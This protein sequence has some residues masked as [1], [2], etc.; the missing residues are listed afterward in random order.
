M[1]DG[2]RENPTLVYWHIPKNKSILQQYRI[3]SDSRR[4]T[5]CT[6]IDQLLGVRRQAGVESAKVEG[7]G[8]RSW[9]G[10]GDVDIIGTNRD[11]DV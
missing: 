9:S 6:T 5:N 1:R 4:R 2:R 7:K 10:K 11:I 8:A 3:N